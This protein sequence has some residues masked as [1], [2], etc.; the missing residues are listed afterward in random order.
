MASPRMLKES[1]MR[2]GYLRLRPADPWLAFWMCSFVCLPSLIHKSM[3][4]DTDKLT[5][6]LS[7][8]HTCMHTYMCI[9]THTK[10]Q[11]HVHT[12]AHTN[13]ASITLHASTCMFTHT[14]T[15]GSPHQYQYTS[16]YMYTSFYTK[17]YKCI[18]RLILTQNVHR[19]YT[20]MCTNTHT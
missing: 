19:M 8:T 12:Q 11:T 5:H 4:T 13:S 9:Y 15:H 14:E 2:A 7:H 17:M 6:A 3:C 10:M 1:A 16:T 18:T 20:H